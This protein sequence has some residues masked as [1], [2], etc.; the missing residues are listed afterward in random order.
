M[1]EAEAGKDGMT[2]DYE[3]EASIIIML[4][5][6]KFVQTNS[7]CN[8]EVAGVLMCGNI[9]CCMVGNLNRH[10]VHWVTDHAFICGVY[11]SSSAQLDVVWA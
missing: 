7:G 2:I 6:V 9:E 5:A 1:S 11:T 10:A 3:R 4:S 8:K